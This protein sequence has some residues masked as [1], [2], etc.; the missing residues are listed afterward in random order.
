MRKT[1]NLASPL[2]VAWLNVLGRSPAQSSLSIGWDPVSNTPTVTLLVDDC[3]PVATMSIVAGQDRQSEETV[4]DRGLLLGNFPFMELPDFT[5]LEWIKS[6]RCDLR[7]SRAAREF[8][9]RRL[10]ITVFWNLEHVQREVKPF[11]YENSN[12][13]VHTLLERWHAKIPSLAIDTTTKSECLLHPHK[14]DL[15]RDDDSQAQHIHVQSLPG[16]VRKNLKIVNPQS[17]L[18]HRRTNDETRHPSLHW[19]PSSFCGKKNL[20]QN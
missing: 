18:K 10:L 1:T 12:E 5:V 14:Q 8:L 15:Y 19:L 9:R 20:F 17:F 3:R 6:A 2:G 4:G 16:G 11:R 13:T 7:L